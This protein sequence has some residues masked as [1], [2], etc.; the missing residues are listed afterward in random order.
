LVAVD[1]YAGVEVLGGGR[2]IEVEYEDVLDFTEERLQNGVKVDAHES[3]LS[4]LGLLTDEEEL[5]ELVGGVVLDTLNP[6]LDLNVFE[7]FEVAAQ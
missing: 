5:V 6:L 4:K 7:L 3:L 1:V 2:H